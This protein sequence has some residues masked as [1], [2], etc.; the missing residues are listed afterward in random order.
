MKFITCGGIAVCLAVS[1][2]AQVA[3]SSFGAGD[4]YQ[5][6]AIW[7]L[8][9]SSEQI[10]AFQFES[11]TTGVLSTI[12]YGFSNGTAGDVTV[13][14]FE[15]SS[16]E[17]GAA[18]ASWTRSEP[19][20]SSPIPS[21]RSISNTNSAVSLTAGSKYWLQLAPGS[22]SF[23]GGWNINDQNIS[24]RVF[25]SQ[26]GSGFYFNQRVGAYRVTTGVVP[27]PA[28]MAALGLGAF[29]LIRKRRRA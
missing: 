21:I 14:L 23:S 2:H 17:K 20:S 18:L 19:D 5:A 1:A 25:V 7:V 16:D 4:S 28:S 12:E 11:A 24:N 27:E 8:G 9:G 3:Y 26:S 22:G 6:N 13:T 29:A 10:V 15:D